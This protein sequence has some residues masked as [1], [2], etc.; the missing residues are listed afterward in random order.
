[1]IF[2]YNLLKKKNQIRNI[3]H[4]REEHLTPL[5]VAV[6]AAKNLT[7]GSI[8]GE[9]IGNTGL[10]MGHFNWVNSELSEN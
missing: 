5:F 2:R 6:G 3:C 7:P 10:H 1:M 8:F 9:R 4:P